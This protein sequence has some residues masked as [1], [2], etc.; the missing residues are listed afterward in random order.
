MSTNI[1]TAYIG[2]FGHDQ[3]WGTSTD[4]SAY[5]LTVATDYFY[6]EDARYIR[7]PYVSGEPIYILLPK[8]NGS[9][10]ANH[11]IQF[12]FFDEAGNYMT[13]DEHSY[14]INYR[15]APICYTDNNATTCACP[16]GSELCENETICVSPGTCD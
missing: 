3:S 15:P 1:T 14:F 4:S 9:S 5:E 16:D 2:V 10:I 8:V 12:R 13:Y 11:L 6:A 7:S